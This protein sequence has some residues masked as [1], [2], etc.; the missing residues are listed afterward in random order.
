MKRFWL[1]VGLLVALLIGGI[2]LGDWMDRTFTTLAR[3]MDQACSLAGQ[4]QLWQAEPIAQST[5]ARWLD[6]R[7]ATAALADHTPME[8]I[9]RLFRELRIYALKQ[10]TV[11]YA[12]T[13]AQLSALLQAMA[14][15]HDISWWHLL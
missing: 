1:G 3:H 15:S 13:C 6:C 4:D 7:N 8:E 9:D 12:A 11:H 14:D 10:E 2:G 5:Y